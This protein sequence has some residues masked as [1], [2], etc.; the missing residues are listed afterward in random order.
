MCLIEKKSNK[1]FNDEYEND[2]DHY[3][4]L[5]CCPIAGASTG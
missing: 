1:A 4:V 2:S 5:E 3:G